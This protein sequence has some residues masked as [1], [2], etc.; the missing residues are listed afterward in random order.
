[1]K[2]R[3]RVMALATFLMFVCALS[4]MAAP[5]ISLQKLYGGKLEKELPVTLS[6]LKNGGA[7]ILFWRSDCAP[8]LLEA[9]LLLEIS[10]SHPNLKIKLVALQNMVEF[11]KHPPKGLQGNVELFVSENNAA[12]ILQEFGNTKSSLPFSV[13]LHSDGSLCETNYG[14]LGK[15]EV[16]HWVKKC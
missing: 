5:L 7:L 14:I 11:K 15:N 3:G 12:E 13:M 9:S 16:N 10:E 8:C 4:G 2:L 6:N 1:M